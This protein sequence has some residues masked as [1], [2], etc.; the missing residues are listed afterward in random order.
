MANTT[1]NKP[2]TLTEFMPSADTSKPSDLQII[3]DLRHLYLIARDEK[4]QRYDNWMRNYRLLHNRVGGTVQNWMP[5]PRDS[6]IYP[7]LS[8]LIAWMTDQEVNVDLIP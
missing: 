7:G 4:R 5:A 2:L 3:S 6:E 1:Y 8:S